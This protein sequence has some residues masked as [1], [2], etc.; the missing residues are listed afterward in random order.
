MIR[1]ARK[2]YRRCLK[3]NT[4]FWSEGAHNRLCARCNRENAG[5]HPEPSSTPRR[6]GRPMR[7]LYEVLKW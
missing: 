4:R 6:N 1:P 7:E 2:K 5:L 3:C